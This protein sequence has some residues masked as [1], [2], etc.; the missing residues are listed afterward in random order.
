MK[1]IKYTDVRS[2]FKYGDIVYACAYT[3]SSTKDARAL[4]QKP[5]RGMFVAGKTK[6][7]NDYA[8]SKGSTGISYF[9]PFKKNG[10]DLAW[11][12]AVELSSRCYGTT[13]QEC[14]E[15]YN[16]LILNKINWHMQE[17]EDLKKEMI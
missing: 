12:R 5:I 10:T 17:I 6:E 11:S 4:H 3:L 14:I 15:V 8:L 13:L 9:V 7:K 1:V 16:Q 2:N